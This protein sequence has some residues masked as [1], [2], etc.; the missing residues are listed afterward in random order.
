M[1]SVSFPTTPHH[2]KDRV[3]HLMSDEELRNE[4]VQLRKKNASLNEECAS[5]QMEIN[6]IYEESVRLQQSTEIEEEKLANQLLRRLQSEELQKRRFHDLI[7]REEVARQKIM[8]QIAQI[9]TEKT[10][11]AGQLGKQES[12]ML[13]LQKKLMEVVTK[14]SEVERELLKERRRYLD[15]LSTQLGLLIEGSINERKGGKTSDAGQSVDSSEQKPMESSSMDADSKTIN[16]ATSIPAF[17][18]ATTDTH[19]AI[20][21]LEKQLNRL[22]CEHAAAVQNLS[23]N[24]VCCAELAKKLDTIQQAAFLDRARASKLK[25]ELK[26][27][28]S[29]LAGLE[30][31]VSQMSSSA[32]SEE[33]SGIPTPTLCCLRSFSLRGRTRGALSS[34]QRETSVSVQPSVDASDTGDDSRSFA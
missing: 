9:R 8:N 19:V 2:E 21:R 28:K 26:E 14:K 30:R 22:L 34:R 6:A 1:M 27:A 7:R 12:L 25:E 13:Q 15:V 5:L 3:P 33:S 24:E 17:E 23:S 11:L 10:D 18:A 16:C 32:I 20:N 31:Q 29:R 4:Y